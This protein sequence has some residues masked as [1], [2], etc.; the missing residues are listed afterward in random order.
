MTESTNTETDFGQCNWCGGVAQKYKSG[1]PICWE[2]WNDVKLNVPAA[3]HWAPVAIRFLSTVDMYDIM[4]YFKKCGLEKDEAQ[5]ML[6]AAQKIFEHSDK[7]LH[8]VPI[9]KLPDD[10]K[11]AR[12]R[13][14]L[15]LSDDAQTGQ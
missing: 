1:S 9:E 15:G 11:R 8:V 12:Y 7:L 5:V 14:Y 10:E 6:K 2:C 4:T 13:K 3:Q